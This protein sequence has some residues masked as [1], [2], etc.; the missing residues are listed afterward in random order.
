MID[1]QHGVNL[2][3]FN[4]MATNT[5]ASHFYV[6]S[7]TQQLTELMDYAK[8]HALAIRTLGE[9]SNLVLPNNVAALVI[10]NEILGVELSNETDDCVE[11]KVGAG[12]N[13][14]QFVT[15]AVN[16][17]YY[18]LENLALIPGT[19]GAAPVQNIGAYGVEAGDLIKLVVAYDTVTNSMVQLTKTDCG[20]AYRDSLFKQQENRF[21]ITQVVFQLKKK[22]TAN[23]S[24]AALAPVK[25]IAELTAQQLFDFIVQTRQEKLPDPKQIPNAGSFFKNPVV[26]QSQYDALLNRFPNIVSYPA[27]HG[28]KLAAGWLIDQAGLKGQSNE[29]GVGCYGKQ[30]LVVINPNRASGDDVL[31]WAKFVQKKVQQLFSVELEVEPRSW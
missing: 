28:V 2:Q 4:T 31:A 8:Q 27:D 23:I 25:D 30:A 7:D 16:Q 14:H 10:K 9:G 17:H 3:N 6:L 22:F 13:W 5:I 21:V 26:S 15:W 12:E 20:F 19:V 24:Y 1:V 11:L 18:G 29:Q